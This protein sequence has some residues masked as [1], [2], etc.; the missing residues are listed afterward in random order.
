MTKSHDATSSRFVVSIMRRQASSLVTRGSVCDSNGANRMLFRTAACAL[1]E[2]LLG[3]I[4]DDRGY[5]VKNQIGGDAD[6]DIARAEDAYLAEF[7]LTLF[8]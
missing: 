2:N 3:D 7:H 1:L 8:G 5:P 4:D 6:T